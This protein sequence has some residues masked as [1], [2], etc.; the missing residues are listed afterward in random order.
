MEGGGERCRGR[1]GLEMG[2]REVERG[3]EGGVERDGG[4]AK[5]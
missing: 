3:M 1:K 4:E 5:E 2:L